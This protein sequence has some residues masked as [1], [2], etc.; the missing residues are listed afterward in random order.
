MYGYCFDIL[1]GGWRCSKYMHFHS[2]FYRNF[3]LCTDSSNIPSIYLWPSRVLDNESSSVVVHSSVKIEKRVVLSSVQSRTLRGQN[4]WRALLGILAQFHSLL[5]LV[6]SSTSRNSST[7]IIIEKGKQKIDRY[8]IPL[9]YSRT[10]CAFS[11]RF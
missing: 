7:S 4:N 1:K 10:S 5:I 9:H 8:F 6:N 11:R 3:F 2:S